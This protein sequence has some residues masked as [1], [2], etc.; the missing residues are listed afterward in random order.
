MITTT[1]DNIKLSDDPLREFIGT[2]ITCH[3]KSNEKTNKKGKKFS[4]KLIAVTES[5]ELWFRTRDG[6]LAMNKR[7]TIAS[8]IPCT[9]HLPESDAP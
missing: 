9:A 7:D 6:K 3:V 5:G 4:A 2:I 8:V 1:C